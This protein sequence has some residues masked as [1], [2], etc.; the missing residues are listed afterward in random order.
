[1]FKSRITA[2]FWNSLEDGSD[3]AQSLE[4]SLGGSEQS[5]W[6]WSL[7]HCIEYTGLDQAGLDQAGLD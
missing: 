1:M 5:Q 6:P 3:E 7:G 4:V 2:A